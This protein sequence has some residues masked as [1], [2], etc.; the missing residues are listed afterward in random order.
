MV[1]DKK[2]II[3]RVEDCPCDFCVRDRKQL[4]RAKANAS[5]KEIIRS[6]RSRG[7]A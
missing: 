1:A 3:A 4:E 2:R 6:K 7:G 5:R